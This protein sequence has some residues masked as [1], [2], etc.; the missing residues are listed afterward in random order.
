[1]LTYRAHTHVLRK[2]S[3]IFSESILAYRD[4]RGNISERQVSPCWNLSS[5]CSARRKRSILPL[6]L[7]LPCFKCTM[8]FT[9]GLESSLP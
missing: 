3:Y 8:V 2:T 6:A 1:M 9:L 5:S 4:Q 7:R